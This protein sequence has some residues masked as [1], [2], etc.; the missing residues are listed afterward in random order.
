M[1]FGNGLGVA[2]D[3]SVSKEM[4]FSK[5]YGDIIAEVSP[6]DNCSKDS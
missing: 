4:L 5:D 2:I 6:E 1:A 3:G